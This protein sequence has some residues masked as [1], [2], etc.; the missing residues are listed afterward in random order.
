MPIYDF[1]C[2]NC[3][4]EFERIVN[5]NTDKVICEQCGNDAYKQ[6]SGTRKSGV[7]ITGGQ[8]FLNNGRTDC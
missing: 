7:R 1:K 3:G 8:R 5:L 6:V 2:D 4:N